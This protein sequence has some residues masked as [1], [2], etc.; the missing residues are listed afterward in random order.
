MVN[1]KSAKLVIISRSYQKPF[2]TATLKPYSM[3]CV[4]TLSACI[5]GYDMYTSSSVDWRIT[6]VFLEM[7]SIVK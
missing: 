6:I 2:V 4:I 1:C 7:Q 5:T 3:P